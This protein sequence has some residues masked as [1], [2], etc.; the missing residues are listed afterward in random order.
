MV[1]LGNY[2]ATMVLLWILHG[3]YD[4]TIVLVRY[5]MAVLML[6]MVLLRYFMGTM[7]L[8]CF[9]YGTSWQLLCYGFKTECWWKFVL[10]VRD[11]K[12]ILFKLREFFGTITGTLCDVPHK[13]WQ[14]TVK[15][16]QSNLL[17][18]LPT[19][20]ANFFLI[21]RVKLNIITS[22]LLIIKYNLDSK[23]G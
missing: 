16:H 2:V 19:V 22:A 17:D 11:Y 18:F 10:V 5:F 13:L 4:A 23:L 8:Q 1:L 7:M 12:R 6:T 20:K 3:N 14:H 15:L 9:Y 21:I